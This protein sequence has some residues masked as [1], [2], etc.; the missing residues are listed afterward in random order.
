MSSGGTPASDTDELSAHEHQTQK[1]Y[2]QSIVRLLCYVL[3]T[4]ILR[5]ADQSTSE[6]FNQVDDASGPP[7]EEAEGDPQDTPD[8][9]EEFLTTEDDPDD[10]ML[11][12]PDKLNQNAMKRAQKFGYLTERQMVA[13]TSYLALLKSHSPSD[14]VTNSSIPQP[15]RPVEIPGA[16]PRS[17]PQYPPTPNFQDNE[18]QTALH[19]LLMSI[20]EQHTPNHCMSSAGISFL[21]LASATKAGSWTHGLKTATIITSLKWGFR[22]ALYRQA[23]FDRRAGMGAWREKLKQHV[24]FISTST[25]CTFEWMSNLATELAKIHANNFQMPSTVLF[26]SKLYLRG[27]ELPWPKVVQFVQR[28]RNSLLDRMEGFLKHLDAHELFT[29]DWRRHDIKDSWNGS[30]SFYSFLTDP[31]NDASWPPVDYLWTKMLDTNKFHIREGD[32]IQWNIPLI[33]DLLSELD[34]I[35]LSLMATLHL[36]GGGTSRGSEVS[37]QFL[38]NSNRQ[39]SVYWM[40]DRFIIRPAYHK[41]SHNGS[42]KDDYVRAADWR[43]S[44][45]CIIFWR[46]CAEL[47]YRIWLLI[48]GVSPSQSALELARVASLAKVVFCL[49]FQCTAEAAENFRDYLWWNGRRLLNADDLTRFIRNLSFLVFG[50]S[51]GILDWR[52]LVIVFQ[53][54]IISVEKDNSQ[55]INR[56]FDDQSAHSTYTQERRYSINREPMEELPYLTI[57]KYVILSVAQQK[58][59]YLQLPL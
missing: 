31:A 9:E 16:D 52:H 29:Y 33:A 59:R 35:G 32:T 44:E 3:R 34:E 53:Q 38:R 55:L 58:V 51:F 15:I 56:L 6:A 41:G 14:T 7:D 18:Y 37:G 54:L 17:R 39:R 2:S 28:A 26:N 43:V 47:R 10:P 20:I 22:L 57:L 5:Q 46:Y 36:T 24:D 40:F 11:P 49:P 19:E 12:R 50:F 27:Q 4:A 30:Q 21:V 42:D 23:T 48:F 25:H 1:K 13:A 8:E 45:I